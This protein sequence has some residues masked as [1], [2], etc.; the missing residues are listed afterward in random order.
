MC[1]TWSQAY[2]KCTHNVLLLML[3]SACRITL[4]SVASHSWS[5][6]WQR[7]VL[8]GYSPL[9]NAWGG[10][11]APS[12]KALGLQLSVSLLLWGQ[13]W[14]SPAPREASL[15]WFAGAVGNNWHLPPVGCEA[16]EKSIKWSTETCQI[17]RL[18]GRKQRKCQKKPL[19][20][21][22]TCLATAQNCSPTAG[23]AS[24]R[25]EFPVLQHEKTQDY[26]LSLTAWHPVTS[27]ACSS[28][29]HTP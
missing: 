12:V 19:W 27:A 21:T 9:S 23:S 17:Q 6:G 5:M 22:A 8:R 11:E 1:C 29:L 15:V 20:G 3:C 2:T 26:P 10:E 4:L 13:Y 25:I 16:R 14:C 7:G 24:A 28:V 18:Q